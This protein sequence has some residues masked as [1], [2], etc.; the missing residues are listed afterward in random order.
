MIL[1]LRCVSLV[2][3][4]KKLS[5]ILNANV[6]QAITRMILALLFAKVFISKCNV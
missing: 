1:L 4:S 3:Q 5:E 6:E 2:L